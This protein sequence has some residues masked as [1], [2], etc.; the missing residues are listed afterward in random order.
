MNDKLKKIKINNHDRI[1]Q[2]PFG[3]EKGYVDYYPEYFQIEHTNRCNAR[4][5]MC[6]HFFLNNKDA[7]DINPKVIDSI[8]PVLKYARNIMI[9]GDG[10]PFLC[11]NIEQ[12]LETYGRSEVKIGANTNLCAISESCFKLIAR[13]FEFLNIS[14]DGC[15]KET[16]EK[17]RRGLSFELFTK[18]LE[19]LQNIA[20]NV[21]KN[22]DCVVMTHNLCEM[23]KIVDF[24]ADFQF[25]KVKFHIMGVNP[26]IKNQ[27]DSI[28]KY[29][30][31]ASSIFSKVKERSD[32]RNI[33]VELPYISGKF[34]ENKV[35]FE[36]NCFWCVD[37]EEITTR[38]KIA[39]ECFGELNLS[40][41]YLAKKMTS[42]EWQ[43]SFYTEHTCVWPIER[44]YIDVK[45]NMTTCC[46][47]TRYYMGNIIEEG[48]FESVWNGENYRKLRMEM[49]NKKMPYFC[50]GCMYYMTEKNKIL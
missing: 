39:M 15:T 3:D 29:S 17:I 19:Q 50:N 43:S 41:D 1:I 28:L 18:K 26:C 23:P 25:D 30:A 20:P 46:Y 44:C 10:E 5:I 32:V 11:K 36:K 48:T 47:N 16:Y 35:D 27:D 31:F 33:V 49:R 21:R 13:E 45:G 42:Q 40:N 38:Q 8:I 12:Y 14:C 37:E 4:C 34:D 6:N 24:A 2:N 7:T 9:N 22:L